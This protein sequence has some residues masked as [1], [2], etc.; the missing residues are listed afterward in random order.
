MSSFHNGYIKG[1]KDPWGAL[2]YG[3]TKVQTVSLY[4]KYLRFEHLSMIDQLVLPFQ[5][6]FCNFVIFIKMVTCH[7]CLQKDLAFWI[8]N[9]KY[10][11]SR[12]KCHVE[13]HFCLVHLLGKTAV[14]SSSARCLRV[15]KT[16]S[17]GLSRI[18][19]EMTRQATMP[20]VDNRRD[21]TFEYMS[22]KGYFHCH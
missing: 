6:R 9:S 7:L 5:L 3:L 21:N 2:L 15:S 12:F 18:C 10:Q 11:L 16:E 22:F 4:R 20:S 19:F 1:Q 13:C 17:Y 14:I 8:W